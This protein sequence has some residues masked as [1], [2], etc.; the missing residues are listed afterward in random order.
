MVLELALLLAE[1]KKV[2]LCKASSQSNIKPLRTRVVGVKSTEQLEILSSI[3]S[4]RE[5]I[6]KSDLLRHLMF[7]QSEINDRERKKNRQK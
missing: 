2:E 7:P 5:V 3:G 4:I 1:A 6:R